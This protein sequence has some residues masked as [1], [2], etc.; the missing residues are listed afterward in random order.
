MNSWAA[1]A[2]DTRSKEA[3][4]EVKIADEKEAIIWLQK[5]QSAGRLV[6]GQIAV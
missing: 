1:A 4:A 2:L 6:C 5:A 3:K